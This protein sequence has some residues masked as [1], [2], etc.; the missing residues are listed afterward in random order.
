[1]HKVINSAVKFIKRAAPVIFMVSLGLWVLGYFPLNANLENSWLGSIGHFI[2]PVFTPLGLDWRYGIAIVMSFL[3]REVFVGALG[4]L[5][6]MEG[7]DENIAGL[8]QNIINEG[9]PLGTGIGLLLFYVIALQCVATVATLKGE[10]GSNKLSWGLYV[11][12][13]LLAYVVAFIAS[14]II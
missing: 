10:T 5:Y 11:F 4:T 1:M 9:M 6:G 12:Y 7:A 3:A 2:E 14:S 13:A 8:A